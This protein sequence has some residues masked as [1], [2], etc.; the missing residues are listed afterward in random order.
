MSDQVLV[1]INHIEQKPNSNK[2]RVIGKGVTVDFLAQFI[3][4][5]EWSIERISANYGLTPAEIHAAW[6]FYYDHQ[7]E[8]DRQIRA[9]N[10]PTILSEAEN[11]RRQAL[12][13][14][15]EG[16]TGQRL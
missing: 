8:I 9:A 2:Y 7:E 3:H 4:D 16:K 13:D 10:T 6:A 1:S 12:A 14:A 5:P 15:Y 11:Q